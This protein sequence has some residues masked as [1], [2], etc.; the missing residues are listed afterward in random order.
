[1]RAGDEGRPVVVGYDGSKASEQAL[2]WGIEEARMR[3]DPLVVCYAWQWPSLSIPFSRETAEIIRRMSGMCSAW[4]WIWRV[5]WLPGC[6]SWV[7]WWRGR[8]RPCW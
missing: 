2:R 1:M 6:G 3:F 8:R 7:R 5:T 4:G